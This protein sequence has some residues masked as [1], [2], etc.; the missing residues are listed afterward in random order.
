MPEYVAALCH[1]P[2]TVPVPFESVNITAEDDEEAIRKAVQW[3]VETVS[4]APLDQ[5][6][7]LQVL[8]NGKAVHSQKIG[9]F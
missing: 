3:R 1:M 7:W 6:T 4:A 2:G 8:L 5:E 9:R